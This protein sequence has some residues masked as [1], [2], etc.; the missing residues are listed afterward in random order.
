MSWR[1]PV[2]VIMRAC[3]EGVALNAEAGGKLGWK[4]AQ[5][6][7]DALLGALADHKADIFTL[8]APSSPSPLAV[9]RAKRMIARLR[10]LAFW[11]Y[12]NEE[13]ALLITDEAGRRRSVADYLP[14]AEVFGDLVAGLADDPAL[15]D[16]YIDPGQ[17]RQR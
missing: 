4:A 11:P 17:R 12:L 5:R 16:R 2:A 14:I 15:L 8:I 7:S 9:K 10:A 3:R 13:G 1:A 6:P